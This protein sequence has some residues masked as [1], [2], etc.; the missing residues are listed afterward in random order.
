MAPLPNM[1]C[2]DID[3]SSIKNNPSSASTRGNIVLNEF[4]FINESFGKYVLSGRGGG[5]GFVFEVF[6]FSWR[7]FGE[8]VTGI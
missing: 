2:E 6:C 1:I 4:D 5:V 3:G 7:E 8:V